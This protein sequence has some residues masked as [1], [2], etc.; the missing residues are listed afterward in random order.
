MSLHSDQR[1]YCRITYWRMRDGVRV[2][3]GPDDEWDVCTVGPASSYSDYGAQDFTRDQAHR[4]DALVS[5]LARAFDAGR[6]AKL[7]EIKSILEIR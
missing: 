2:A 4:R 5:L 6:G 7:R 1:L 3:C